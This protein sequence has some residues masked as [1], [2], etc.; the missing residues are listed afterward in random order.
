[1][2]SSNSKNEEIPRIA[3][4]YSVNKAIGLLRTRINKSSKRKMEN[5]DEKQ[6]KVD[7]YC[8]AN[9]IESARKKTNVPAG[10]SHSYAMLEMRNALMESNW[11]AMQ[12]IYPLLLKCYHGESVSWRY[13]F[14]IHLCS[15]ASDLSQ[16]QEFIEM[17]L[18]S[19]SLNPNLLE[20][21]M[22]L[23]NIES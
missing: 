10:F 16:F 5:D 7:N 23:K 15:P 8:A 9:L 2:S 18:G 20:K 11:S 12:E 17:C 14:L 3:G 4:K 22:S 6:I 13:I 21:L 19:E 1:M